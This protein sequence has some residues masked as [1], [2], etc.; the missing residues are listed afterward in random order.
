MNG[1]AG[2]PLLLRLGLRRERVIAP[3]WILL[4]VT[5]ALVMVAYVERNMGT[6]ELK[7]TYTEMINR[8]AFFRALGGGT[9]EPDLGVLSSWRSGGFL[10]VMNGLAALMSVIRLTRADED[11]GRTE[12]LRAAVVGRYSPLTAALLVAGGV[13]LAGGALTA[14][15]LVAIGLEP[16]GSIAY[17]AAITAAGWVF[18]AIGAVA[19]QLARSAHTARVM[20]LAVLGAA[21]LLRYAGDASGQAWMVRAS[22]IGWSHLV[23]P[24]RDERWWMLAVPL[25]VAAVLAAAAYGL[26]GRRDLGAGLVSERRGPASAPRLRGP[27]S[28][29]WRLHRG[30][31]ASWAAGIAVFAAAAGGLSTLAHQLSEAPGASVAHLME[32]FGGSGASPLHAYVWPIILIFGYII[33]LYPVIMVQRLRADEA[34]GRAEAVQAT[35]MT[36]LRWA[37]GHLLVAALGTAALL[38]VAG[39]AFGTLFGVLVGDPASDVPRILAAALGTLPAAWL[40]GA[41]GVLAYGLVPR[42]CVA[43]SWAVWVAVAALGRIAGPLYGQWGGTPFEPFHYLPDTVAGAPFDPVPALVLAALSALVAGGGLL[44]LHRRDIG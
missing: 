6:F 42:A 26:A 2:T 16:T 12:L 9:V 44:A 25:A 21:Y 23:E 34:A 19:A 32:N 39:L 28:L 38:A 29:A 18:A 20:A 10:Y 31:L 7:A 13:S 40:V 24:Y 41:V 8:N 17:G 3:W 27:I 36:R 43:I 11:S 30:L 33:A 5:M 37:G 14:V 4:L 1:L 22:P 35:P 15:V